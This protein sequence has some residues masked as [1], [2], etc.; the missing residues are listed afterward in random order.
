MIVP[1]V[2]CRPAVLVPRGASL[3]PT[4]RNTVVGM[5]LCP[6]CFNSPDNCEC[7]PPFRPPA[8]VARGPSASP[9]R[10]ATSRETAERVLD[11][12]EPGRRRQV[13][14]FLEAA[15]SLGCWIE[16]PHAVRQDYVNIQPP[17]ACGAGRL[18]SVTRSTGR[19]EFQTDTYSLAEAI[20]IADHFTFLI[21]RCR[22]ESGDHARRRRERRDGDHPGKGHPCV[23]TRQRM[24]TPPASGCL[25]V[26]TTGRW[27][28]RSSNSMWQIL[29]QRQQFDRRGNGR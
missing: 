6:T 13:A 2:V 14:S 8:G 10:P 1:P 29:D 20:D 18:C 9:T 12:V 28:G 25:R 16:T 3:H 19:V 15:V 11:Q 4:L 27:T 17:R 22:R 23:Q 21:S 24:M 26:P 7:D 5:A